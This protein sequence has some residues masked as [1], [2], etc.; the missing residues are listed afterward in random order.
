[1][2]DPINECEYTN[3]MRIVSEE[4]RMGF[5]YCA[6]SNMFELFTFCIGST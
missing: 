1:M 3:E 2:I 6:F 4:L 5:R